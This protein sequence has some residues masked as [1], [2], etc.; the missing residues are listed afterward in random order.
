MENVVKM[1]W[2]R[3]KKKI[4]VGGIVI[5]GALIFVAT[6]KKPEIPM[7]RADGLPFWV[8]LLRPEDSGRIII[9]VDK[10]KVNHAGFWNTMR[11]VA[12]E[13]IDQMEKDAPLSPER[14]GKYECGVKHSMIMGEVNS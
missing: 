14:Y 10:E 4:I 5:G 11:D 7:T 8:Y 6:R 13:Y 12:I 2:K 3:H 1:Y 9:L